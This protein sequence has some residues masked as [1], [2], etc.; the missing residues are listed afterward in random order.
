M[1]NNSNASLYKSVPITERVGL[2]IG[3]DAFNVFN[4]PGLALPD[5][6]TGILS[7]R[8]SGQGARTLQYTARLTW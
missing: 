1:I 2:R 7:L 4:Q 6:T 5:P 8:L 3:V